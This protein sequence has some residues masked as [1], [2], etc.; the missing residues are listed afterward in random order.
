VLANL[1]DIKAHHQLGDLL[2]HPFD[3][4]LLG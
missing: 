1:T 4:R 2:P 3:G